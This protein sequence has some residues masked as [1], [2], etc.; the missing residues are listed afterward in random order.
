ME[1]YIVLNVT[2]G[3]LVHSAYYTLEQAEAVKRLDE[4]HRVDKPLLWSK[5]EIIA[6]RLSLI[7]EDS[8]E[9]RNHP[10]LRLDNFQR[11]LVY[12]S[13]A[14]S[15][16]LIAQSIERDREKQAPAPETLYSLELAISLPE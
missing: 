2:S 14:W 13:L 16:R 6:T 10:D 9:L 3:P 1:I 11:R 15:E 8:I 12:D 4:A 7:E 5:L